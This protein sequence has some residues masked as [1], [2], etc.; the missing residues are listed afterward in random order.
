MAIERK[1]DTSTKIAV[2]GGAPKPAKAPAAST[3]KPAASAG[4]TGTT[5]KIAQVRADLSAAR[6][7]LALN[8]LDSPAKIKML[9]KELARLLTAENAKTANAKETS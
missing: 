9:R 6:R 1:A 8:K 3:R 5:P 7:D 2:A 4:A